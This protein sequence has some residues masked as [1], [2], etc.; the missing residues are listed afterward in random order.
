MG[1]MNGHF[2]PGIPIVGAARSWKSVQMAPWQQIDPT[3]PW[4][5]TGQA[6]GQAFPKGLWLVSLVAERSDGMPVMVQGVLGGDVLTQPSVV[7]TRMQQL[8]AALAGFRDCACG[9]GG[10]TCAKH[11]MQA[12]AQVRKFTGTMAPEGHG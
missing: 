7:G 1:A 11:R 9:P 8:F 6:V 12:E 5:A 3:S 10:V 4:P 2:A